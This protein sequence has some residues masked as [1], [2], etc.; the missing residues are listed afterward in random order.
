MTKGPFS[1]NSPLWLCS[2]VPRISVCILRKLPFGISTCQPPPPPPPTKGTTF[3]KN[4]HLYEPIK[5]IIFLTTNSLVKPQKPN[6]RHIYTRG[7]FLAKRGPGN[8]AYTL[9]ASGKFPSPN[10]ARIFRQKAEIPPL[11]RSDS[12]RDQR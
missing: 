11:P 1:V 7:T 5:S 12:C 9:Y 8:E 3:V 2:D 4:K 10:I 6:A